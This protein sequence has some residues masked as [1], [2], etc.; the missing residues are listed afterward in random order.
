MDAQIMP[1]MPVPKG[2]SDALQ[3]AMGFGG[4]VM[5]YLTPEMSP[6]ASAEFLPESI[7]ST[8]EWFQQEPEPGGFRDIASTIG[9]YASMA[10]LEPG[11]A[12]PGQAVIT[13]GGLLKRA[14]VAQGL[15][16]IKSMTKPGAP[17]RKNFLEATASP[18]KVGELPQG[19]PDIRGGGLHIADQ[20]PSGVTK[21]W[22]E[23]RFG[24]SEG[25]VA[26]QFRAGA[27]GEIRLAEGGSGRRIGAELDLPERGSSAANV[28]R[29]V[30]ELVHVG[31]QNARA[32][33][34]GALTALE[35][36]VIAEGGHPKAQYLQSHPA[37]AGRGTEQ[38]DTWIDES[39]A[40]SIADIQ[41]GNITELQQRPQ[42][43]EAL[44]KY[45]GY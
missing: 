41:Q 1:Q 11:S 42:F 43:K 40:Y 27:R 36:A 5:D 9:K 12:G 31:N 34:R 35:E 21:D 39:V 16:D 45:M 7:R 19:R 8:Q 6:G 26:G 4:D 24:T 10:G 18:K 44:L 2:L 17:W 20:P 37:A 23:R 32:H 3:R 15:K 13:G 33:N 29:N 38:F 28:E 25:G 30:H 14:E 22:L